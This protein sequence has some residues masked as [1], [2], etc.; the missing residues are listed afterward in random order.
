MTLERVG[1]D[2]DMGAD[3][4]GERRAPDF[5]V[6]N[7]RAFLAISA[8]AVKCSGAHAAKIPVQ[9]TVVVIGADNRTHEVLGMFEGFVAVGIKDNV[10]FHRDPGGHGAGAC[11]VGFVDLTGDRGQLFEDR[12]MGELGGQPGHAF[13]DFGAQ[14]GGKVT[15]VAEDLVALVFC[16]GLFGE[17]L[18]LFALRL[19][20][21]VA[22]GGKGR[23]DECGQ[24]RNA[25]PDNRCLFAGQ[26]VPDRQ[27][28]ADQPGGCAKKAQKD[29]DGPDGPGGCARGHG[30]LAQFRVQRVAQP[31]AQE[32]DRQSQCQKHARR[33]E[34]DPPFAR[35]QEALADADQGAQ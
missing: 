15:V 26:A 27:H 5:A 8:Q 31:V 34:Q 13:V 20:V 2:H 3:R 9:V 25:C 17:D 12:V 7:H 22:H 28:R 30:R 18:V 14:R 33:E 35:E 16:F 11:G 19:F 4:G 1:V 10:L 29:Q 32:V 21:Q 24:E 23:S 6:G